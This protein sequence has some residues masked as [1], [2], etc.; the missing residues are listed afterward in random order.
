MDSITP[1]EL[2][3]QLTIKPKRQKMSRIKREQLKWGLIF[4]SPW[5]IGFILFY[6]IPFFA[7]FGFSLY[8]FNLAVPDEAK[9]VGANNWTRAL[10]NDP[11]V[12]GSFKATFIFALISL[13]M[14]MGFALF[15]AVIMNS[16]YLMGKSLFR[17][18]F[19]MPTMVPLV[20]AVIIWAGVLN[21]QQGWFNLLLENVLGIDAIGSDGILWLADPQLI[22]FTLSFIGLWGVGNTMLITLAGLQNVPTELYEAAQIDGASWFRQLISITVPMISPVIFYNL[23]LGA[24]NLMQYF[25]VPYVLNGGTGFPDGTTNFIGIYFFNQSFSFFNM[26]YGATLAWLIFG[27]SLLLTLILFGSSRYWVY[28]AGE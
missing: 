1:T 16:K 21:P 5:I 15:L 24:I 12:V 28:Y 13:P 6:V 23:V 3:E 27:V 18:L 7:S 26:G 8:D 10:S 22:Y 20:A 4:L 17:T 14:S 11:Q 25:L 9:F 2:A 19:Y